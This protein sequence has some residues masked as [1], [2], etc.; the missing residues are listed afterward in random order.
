MFMKKAS[1]CVCAVLLVAAAAVCAFAYMRREQPLETIFPAHAVELA[2]VRWNQDPSRESVSLS[3]EQ[4]AVLWDTMDQVKYKRLGK[5][6]TLEDK[7][8]SVVCVIGDA[9]YE[10]VFSDY[11]GGRV[12][13]HEISDSPNGF[14][15][16]YEMCPSGQDVLE[17]L[18]QFSLEAP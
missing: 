11:R 12:M 14:I 1:V 8:A 16:F 13:F 6:M 3:Q 18:N 15:A 17:L 5:K 10:I 2:N 9:L 7:A 4:M